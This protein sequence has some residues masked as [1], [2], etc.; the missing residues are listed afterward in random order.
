MGVSRMGVSRAAE[1]RSGLIAI[2]LNLDSESSGPRRRAID[3]ARFFLFLAVIAVAACAWSQPAQPVSPPSPRLTADA[4]LPADPRA[5]PSVGQSVPE[6]SSQGSIHGVVVGRDEAVY[7][8]AQI[9]LAPAESP[10]A[11]SSNTGSSDAGSNAPPAR[12]ATTD[13]SGRFNLDGVPSGAFKLTVSAPGFATQV[14]SGFLRPGQSYEAPAVVLPVATT[15]SEVE[16]TASEHEIVQEQLRIEETQ[17]VFGIIP[18]FY[19]TYVPDAPPLA[20]RQ[21]FSLAWRSSIDPITFLATGAFAGVEQADNTFSG[22]GQGAQ[23]Y[24]KRYAANYADG[25]ISTMIGG[26]ILPS[27]LKQDPRYFYKGTGTTRSRVL[28][29]IANAVVCKG[30]NGKWQANYSGILGSLAAGGISNLY[31]PASNRHGV[32]LTFES[33]LLGTAGSAVQNL[34]QEL[35]VRRLTPRIPNYRASNP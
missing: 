23:G 24:A 20:S 30:D 18:N 34:F 14:V 16:V 11:G 12:T 33:T 7:E 26:A 5:Q 1:L 35:I 27:V 8:G 21:K 28:Y 29:A 17:R 4:A 6:E 2:K 9:A 13:S 31:Y 19:V 22:Y 25:F 10:D 15:A 32:T 3:C